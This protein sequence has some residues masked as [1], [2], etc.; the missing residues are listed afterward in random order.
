[1]TVVDIIMPAQCVVR[2]GEFTGRSPKDRYFVQ[3]NKNKKIILCYSLIIYFLNEV[4][5]FN[6]RVPFKFGPGLMTTDH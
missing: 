1:M 5:C 3:T 4:T 2:T 6:P